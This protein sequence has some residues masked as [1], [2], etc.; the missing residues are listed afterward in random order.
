MKRVKLCILVPAHWEAQMGGS[1]YQAKV[2][3]DHLLAHY[4]VDIA[5][6]TTRADPNFKP[7][8]YRIV[9]FS[10][11]RGLRRY[12]SFFDVARLYRALARER[13]DIILQFVGSAHLGIAALY[14]RRHGCKL[15]WRVTNDPS[16]EPDETSW[17]KPHLKL[18]RLFM[19]FGIRNA[20]LILAQTD[21]QRARLE[22]T[23][24]N[25]PVQVLPNFHPAAPD[26]G[27]NGAV[28]KQVAWIANLKP[29]KNPGAF[30]RL[31]RRFAHRADVRFVMVG[32]TTDSEWTRQQL[33]E[34]AATENLDYRGPISQA[35]VN[36]LLE[37]TDLLVNTSDHEGFSN[38]FIQA[39]MRRGPVVSL[40]VDP[41]R[42]LSR[43]GLGA[44]TGDEDALS[45][46]V[47][48]L[49]DD[50]DRCAAI[51]AR[52]RRYAL[53]HHAESNIETL[54]RLLRLPRWLSDLAAP[55]L[56]R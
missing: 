21:Y 48:A 39:W 34:I 33:K 19:S 56:S 5:Y 1:Q 37:Q 42:L 47:A 15:I 9:P 22:E 27:R 40:R 54:A 17:R 32:G 44:V 31:A 2:L 49:L 3:V 10:D 46:Q 36:S 55:R 4:D 18:E 8:G 11:R 50:P 6:L 53:E 51:G 41:D 20:T 43:G 24:P 30:V 52:A 16:V 7:D 23:F 26:C 13:P 35:A 38:T 25:A 28:V 45:R 12:G 14:A 29:L